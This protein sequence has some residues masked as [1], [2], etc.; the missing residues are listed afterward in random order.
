VAL[1]AL[2]RLKTVR[3][4]PPPWSVDDPAPKLGQTCYIVRDGTGHECAKRRRDTVSLPML[5]LLVGHVGT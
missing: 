5:L 4:F 3:R 2:D 1:D